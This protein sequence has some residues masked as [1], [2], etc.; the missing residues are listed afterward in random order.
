MWTTKLSSLGKHLNLVIRSHTV[1]I[2]KSRAN[3]SSDYFTNRQD[4]YHLFSSKDLTSYFFKVHSS[5][6]RLSFRLIPSSDAIGFALVW[7]DSN[8]SPSPLQSPDV[9]Q[10]CAMDV[11]EPHLGP[12][13]S[14]TLYATQSGLEK[15]TSIVY[16]VLSLPSLVP[17]TH[18]FTEL[19]V[20]TKLLTRLSVP[21][22]HPSTWTFTAGYFNTTP[23]LQRLLL[24]T[25]PHHGTVLT[26]HPLANGFFG[27]AGLS[28]MLPAAYTHLSKE[29]MQAIRR[30]GLHEDIEVREWKRGSPSAAKGEKGD[31]E[32]WTYHAKGIWVSLPE[33]EPSPDDAAAAEPD[34]SITVVGSSNYTKRSYELDLEANVLIASTDPSVRRRLGE[35]VR[36]LGE[37]AEKVDE[38]EFK[39]PER[40]VGVGVRLAMWAVRALGGAL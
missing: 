1:L 29:F 23:S 27:S 6:C 15:P 17:E 34:P 38:N 22:L 32:R 28:G 13:T 39:K 35:E 7:P 30:Q 33:P 31:S 37:F 16:P 11:M 26:A 12:S 19:P 3:L 8:P 21:P 5:V 20:L 10:K 18:P 25:R 9:F 4:R 40:R 24:W 36:W 2:S 14:P